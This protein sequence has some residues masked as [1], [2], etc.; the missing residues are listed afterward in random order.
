[1]FSKLDWVADNK[2]EIAGV[3]LAR[4]TLCNLLHFLISTSAARSVG[5][6]QSKN[7][8]FY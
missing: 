8:M 7:W 5:Y 4:W 3:A 1:M 6:Y 2:Y